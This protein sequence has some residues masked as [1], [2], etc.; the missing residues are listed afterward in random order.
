MIIYI[1]MIIHIHGN[2]H[3]Q[4]DSYRLPNILSSI[5]ILIKIFCDLNNATVHGVAKESD[6][7]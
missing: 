3:F 2:I 6:T 1:Y 4:A 5:Y 7:T